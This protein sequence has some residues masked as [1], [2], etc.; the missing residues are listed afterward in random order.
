[1]KIAV[2]NGP[3]L[4]FLGIREPQIYGHTT[5][6]DLEQGLSDYSKT[7]DGVE[8][9]FF[10]SNCEGNLIDFLQKCYYD[11]ID[12]IIMNPGALTHY[13]YALTDA[14]KSIA[15]PTVEVHISNI[16]AREEFRR[17]SVTAVNCLGIV[18][19]FG[20]DSYYIALDGLVRQLK[21]KK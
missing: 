20:L 14:I 19:G 6:D 12:G 1:M 5:L 7:L 4:N 10:Q 18:G 15:I 13:S 8:L 2:I 21:N 17:H 3:N 9:V 16:H 11:K